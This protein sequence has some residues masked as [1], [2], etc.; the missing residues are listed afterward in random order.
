MKHWL[1]LF[2]FAIILV[3]CGSPATVTNTPFPPTEVPTEAPTPSPE[4]LL[5]QEVKEKFELAGI[6]LA[7][8]QNAQ[9]DK[10]GLHITLESGEVI[11]LT[12]DQ[13]QKGMYNGQDNVLQYRDEANQNAVYAFDKE[14]GKWA[15]SQLPEEM[16]KLFEKL[17]AKLG[18]DENGKPVYYVTNPADE[19]VIVGKMNTENKWEEAD[20]IKYKL[21]K[22]IEEAEASGEIMDTEY[23]L[24]GGPGQA[25]KLNGEPFPEDVLTGLNIE[26][27]KPNWVDPTNDQLNFDKK[28]LSLLK[29]N[30]DKAPYRLVGHF[31]YKNILNGVEQ[32]GYGYVWQWKNPDESFV[33]ITT[34][35]A[36]KL[37]STSP[38]IMTPFP[39]FNFT[40]D[41]KNLPIIDKVAHND[42]ANKLMFEWA[43]TDVVPSELQDQALIGSVR[44]K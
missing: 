10:D 38:Y 40:I 43:E 24:R 26:V 29:E 23:V 2:L 22:T 35:G 28:S 33:Y 15:K 39:S 8:M 14:T 44:F 21:Y 5:P 25:A 20:S 37:K 42:E 9:Y 31:L 36:G 19:T 30:P 6:D 34:I 4:S 18:E 32:P 11:V 41:I 7:Q 1:S 27:V 13:L 16:E 3:A 12:N 17:G